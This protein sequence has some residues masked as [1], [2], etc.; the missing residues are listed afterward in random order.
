[1]SA[2]TY[3]YELGPYFIPFESGNG[4]Q[5]AKS[6][7]MSMKG[8]NFYSNFETTL[9]LAQTQ[10]VGVIEV[11]VRALRQELLT[12]LERQTEFILEPET[13][14]DP[15]T[16]FYMPSLSETVITLEVYNDGSGSPSGVWHFDNE[17]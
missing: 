12:F 8:E 17:S 7:V 5:T 11:T 15:D 9:P 1:M 4:S 14:L 3:A 13:E 10:P 2:N 16:V 6:Q